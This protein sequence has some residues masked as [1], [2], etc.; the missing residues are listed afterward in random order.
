MTSEL[1]SWWCWTL[2]TKSQPHF[3]RYWLCSDPKSGL[4]ANFGSPDAK[5]ARPHRTELADVVCGVDVGILLMPM[6]IQIR[7][8]MYFARFLGNRVPGGAELGSQSMSRPPT[9][10]LLMFYF[11]GTSNMYMVGSEKTICGIQCYCCCWCCCS[12]WFERQKINKETFL[13]ISVSYRR[14]CFDGDF[15]IPIEVCMLRI[16]RRSWFID[17]AWNVSLITDDCVS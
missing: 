17:G 11:G 5:A 13:P 2:N 6:Y 1:K 9:A 15:G 7:I 10:K 8:N 14:F 12:A 3:N 16:F 4:I